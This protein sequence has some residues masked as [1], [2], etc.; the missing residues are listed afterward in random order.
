MICGIRPVKDPLK[1]IEGWK[2]AKVNAT[3]KIVGPVIDQQYSK[4]V[5]KASVLHR[6]DLISFKQLE[7]NGN[8]RLKTTAQFSIYHFCLIT[9]L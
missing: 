4:K 8:R 1:A 5:F 6:F 7:D 2:M 3:L 9:N